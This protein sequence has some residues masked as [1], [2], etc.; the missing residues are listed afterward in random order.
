MHT[1]EIRSKR[2]EK[3]I[4]VP[5]AWRTDNF[6]DSHLKTRGKVNLIAWCPFFELSRPVKRKAYVFETPN[7]HKCNYSYPSKHARLMH[8]RGVFCVTCQKHA[9]Y[10]VL[11][12]DIGKYMVWMLTG[13]GEPFT[14][15]H[16]IPRSKGGTN[17]SV[18]LKVMCAACNQKKADTHPEEA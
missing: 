11:V 15:D 13:D 6:P 4:R 5:F 17:R 16:H 3:N 1:Y 7:G 12:Q 2:W 10:Y 8:R 18:N 14:L 9:V